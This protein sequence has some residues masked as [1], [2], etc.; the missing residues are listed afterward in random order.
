MQTFHKC[1]SILWYI[2]GFSDKHFLISPRQ[3]NLEPPETQELQHAEQWKDNKW[4]VWPQ[5]RPL[6][7]TSH[8]K[9]STLWF[10][11]AC[12]ALT[13]HLYI[14]AR[15]QSHGLIVNLIAYYASATTSKTLEQDGLRL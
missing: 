10:Y 15:F 11:D 3:P 2:E 1:Q 12:N 5:L 9:H 13:T 7:W 6:A 14:L 8:V 4:I